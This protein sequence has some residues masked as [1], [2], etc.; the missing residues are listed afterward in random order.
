M[1]LVLVFTNQPAYSLFVHRI[2]DEVSLTVSESLHHLCRVAADL[3]AQADANLVGKALRQHVLRTQMT[4]MIVVVGF[5]AS[6]RQGY[7]FAVPLD[8]LQIELVRYGNGV[9]NLP[10]WGDHRFLLLLSAGSQ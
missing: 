3:H 6:Q 9:G 4:A 8:V 10:P 1:Q 7:Q 2:A 5:R